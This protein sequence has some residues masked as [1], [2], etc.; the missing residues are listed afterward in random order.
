[1]QGRLP[2]RLIR[3]MV[4]GWRNKMARTSKAK[5]P[6]QK[7]PSAKCAKTDEPKQVNLALQGGG[8]HG[9][10]TWGVLD[11][12]L[13]DER[14]DIEAISGTSAGA[15]N[16]SVLAYG[17]LKGG[18]S[19]A[20][21]MLGEFWQRV[22]QAAAMSMLQPTFYDRM[23]G[24]HNMGY[25]PGFYAMDWFT[26]TLS[27]YQ[28]NPF[29]LNPLR[30]ILDDMVDFEAIRKNKE[31]KLF[32]NATNVLTGKIKVFKTAELT[33]DMVMASA[34]LPH[35]FQTVIVDEQPYWDG[36]YS[37]NPAIFPLFYHC[38]SNDI[39]IVQIKPAAD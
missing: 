21:A 2:A 1:M 32:I 28:Y 19:Q 9:A 18:R 33:R 10:F 17:L 26:R 29:D 13:E 7:K 6:V 30:D 34:C 27:P 23:T 11:R 37:G 35:M 25:S 16:A 5:G 4:A 15:M 12:L 14:I 36:G 3:W 24:T 38:A 39:I 31:I 8:S 20:R 22:S